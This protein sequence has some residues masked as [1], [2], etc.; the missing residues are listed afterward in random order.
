M[1][2]TSKNGNVLTKYYLQMPILQKYVI[3]LTGNKDYSILIQ[4]MTPML[5]IPLT[6]GNAGNQM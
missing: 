3:E 5:V 6:T 2:N 1:R 4:G